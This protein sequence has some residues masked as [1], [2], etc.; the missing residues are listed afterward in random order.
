MSLPLSHSPWSQPN[1]ILSSSSIVRSVLVA[2][3]VAVA[4]VGGGVLVA[5]AVAVAAVGGGGGGVLVA[6]AVA[7]AAVGGGGGGVLAVL[8]WCQT[9]AIKPCI[10]RCTFTTSS[11]LC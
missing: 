2:V 11:L 7:V 6:V 9:T 3:A 4:A 10:Y 5:V 8:Q 1:I